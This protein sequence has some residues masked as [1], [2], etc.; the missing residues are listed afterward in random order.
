M[1]NSIPKFSLCQLAMPLTSLD[2]DLE[3]CSDLGIHGLGIDERKLDARGDS[4]LVS[5]LR[6]REIKPSICSPRVLS[7]LP[8]PQLPGPSD[9]LQRRR[10]I[11]ASVARLAAIGADTVLLLTGPVG[12]FDPVTARKVV[13]DGLRDAV[14]VAASLNV[15][16]AFEPMSE[17]ALRDPEA[18]AEVGIPRDCSFIGTFDAAVTLMEEVGDDLKIVYDVWHLWD[19]PNVLEVT[20]RYAQRIA[21]VQISDYRQPTRHQDDR[22]LP[23]EGLS[24]LPGIVAALEQGGFRGWYDLEVFS[25]LSLPDSIWARPGP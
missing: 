16:L 9:P 22:L 14:S 21:G 1:R 20:R 3:I 11:L 18:A 4:K 15:H 13:I 2:E 10:D 7:L 25:D 24:D 8:S 23:G 6:R 17:R 5:E 19:T 12:D